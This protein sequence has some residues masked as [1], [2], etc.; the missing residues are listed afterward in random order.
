[1]LF[2]E[3]ESITKEIITR[4][5]PD[6]YNRAKLANIDQ[7]VLDKLGPFIIPTVH[8]RAPVVP[9]FFL[10]AKLPNGNVDI[11]KQQATLNRAL[12]ARAMYKLQL[13]TAGKL[14]YNSNAYTITSTY[15]NSQL[16]IYTIYIT[17]PAGPGQP[18]EYYMN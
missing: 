18:P 15:Y 7:K 9:N 13:Y 11:A 2:I 10:E 12:G 4:A 5:K 17:L 3:L 8:A 16:K 6:F 1:M 14:I